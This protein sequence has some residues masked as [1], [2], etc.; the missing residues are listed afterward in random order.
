MVLPT[1]SFLPL[2]F[3]ADSRLLTS[4]VCY[5][6][7][8]PFLISAWLFLKNFPALMCTLSFLLFCIT[9]LS[10]IDFFF[11]YSE[12]SYS[13]LALLALLTYVVL[14]SWRG[15]GQRRSQMHESRLK[16]NGQKVFSSKAG[17]DKVQKIRRNKIKAQS[18]LGND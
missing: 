13:C 3:L 8:L 14:H 15:R 6:Y 7:L 2:F 10:C 1:Y 11:F 16:W 18:T 17:K 5:Y 12:N 9:K 4:A